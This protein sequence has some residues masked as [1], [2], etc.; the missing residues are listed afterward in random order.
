MI[1][2][3][4]KWIGDRLENAV[5]TKV[6]VIDTLYITPKIK[7]IRFEGNLSKMDFILG[8]A[9]VIRVSEIE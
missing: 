7:K 6:T 9:S 4:P 2:R 5:G 8:G 1:S 3:M